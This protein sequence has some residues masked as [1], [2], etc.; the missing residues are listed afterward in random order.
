MPA[1]NVQL[2]GAKKIN[3]AGEGFSTATSQFHVSYLEQTQ[4]I[5]IAHPSLRMRLEDL[6]LKDEIRTKIHKWQEPPPPAKQPK[7]LERFIINHNI[8]RVME[9]HILFLYC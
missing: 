9:G 1:C 7:N 5:Q 6:A 4:I 8:L 2:L 3:L